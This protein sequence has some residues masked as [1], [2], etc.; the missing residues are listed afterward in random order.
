P[1]SSSSATTSRVPPSISA[2]ACAPASAGSRCAPC[3]RRTRRPCSA[4]SPPRPAP[5]PDTSSRCRPSPRGGPPAPAPPRTG[6]RSSPP[7][8]YTASS[9]PI[10]PRRSH[11]QRWPID[12]R[13]HRP[14]D[15]ASR[16]HEGRRE[17]LRRPGGLV[18][19]RGSA[20]HTGSSPARRPRPA[21][22]TISFDKFR[23]LASCSKR[24]R[25]PPPQ[26]LLQPLVLR[27]LERDG[28][29]AVVRI[30][31]LPGAYDSRRLSRVLSAWATPE[32]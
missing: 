6:S 13:F 26:P 21:A 22:S 3:S 10:R 30:V 27:Q 18:L 19:L 24:L 12:R 1:A 23:Q 29:T 11:A 2:S 9:P 14:R 25:N 32:A 31:R 16:P 28:Q 8:P 5:R 17:A 15:Q 4:G 7:P 20:L